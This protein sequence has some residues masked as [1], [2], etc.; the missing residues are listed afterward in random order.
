MTQPKAKPEQRRR[1]EDE[2]GWN[3]VGGIVSSRTRGQG[4][5][6]RPGATSSIAIPETVTLLL[7]NDNAKT[8]TTTIATCEEDSSSDEE[9]L[10]PPT[11]AV[12]NPAHTRVILEVTH[13]QDLTFLHV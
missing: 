8:T 12:K 9:T 1:A 6:G 4:G 11:L 5:N 13:L 7:N 3:L 10:P 2:R